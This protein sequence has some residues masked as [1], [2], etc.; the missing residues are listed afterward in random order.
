M[1]R[2]VIN[3]FLDPNPETRLSIKGVIDTPW[4]MKRAFSF[5]SQVGSTS[6]SSLLELKSFDSMNAFDII[7]RSKSFNL[8]GLLEDGERKR[9]QRF[10]SNETVEVVFER[11]R[12]AGAKQ[13]CVLIVEILEVAEKMLMVEVKEEGSVNGYELISWDKLR[14]DLQDILLVWE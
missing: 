7:T 12:E 9:A 11:V 10:S 3:G 5:E 8:S 14:D 13:G 1:A 4:F 2:Q 6:S